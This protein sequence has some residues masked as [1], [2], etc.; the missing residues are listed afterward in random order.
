MSPQKVNYQE[1][2]K[3]VKDSLREDEE[4]YIGKLT[5]KQKDKYMKN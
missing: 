1:D 3:E 4:G 5:E 2:W